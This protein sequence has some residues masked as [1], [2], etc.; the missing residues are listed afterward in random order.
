MAIKRLTA[1]EMVQLSTPWVNPNDQAGIALAKL[2]LLAGLLPQLKAAHEAIFAAQVATEDPRAKA[3][4]QA[5][6]EL[7]ATHDALTRGIYGSLTM[8]AEFSPSAEELLRLRDML[9]PEGLEHTRKTYRGEAGHA[10][11]IAAR[12]DDGVRARLKSVTLHDKNLLDVVNAWLA[13]AHKLGEL[14]EERARL[15]APAATSAA[16]LNDARIAWIRVT[17][18]LV[19]NAELVKLDKED[20]RILFSAL[21][22]AARTADSRNRSPKEPT[23]V[24]PTGEPAPSGGSPPQTTSNP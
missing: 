8:L 24:N 2:P 16:Q 4:S 12:L 14:E 3:L 20:D 19:A 6:A 10:A 13:A 18:A 5:E 22:A 21:R 23:P 11:L 7:D 15:T 1:Q 9:L 17:N